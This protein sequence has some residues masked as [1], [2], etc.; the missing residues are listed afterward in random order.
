MLSMPEATASSTPYWMIGL[1]TTGSISF[2]CAL[3]AGRNRVPRPAAG[4]TALRT[5][6]A[7]SSARFLAEG[8]LLAPDQTPDVASMARDDDRDDASHRSHLP[9]RPPGDDERGDGGDRGDERRQRR[10]PA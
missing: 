2:G 9:R 6:L 4:M 3:V 8:A 1:S 10:L 7:M 5:R